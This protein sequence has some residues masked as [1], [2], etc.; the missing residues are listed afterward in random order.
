MKV[1]YIPNFDQFAD[2]YLSTYYSSGVS[3]LKRAAGGPLMLLLGALGA[4]WVADRVEFWLL[5][6]PLLL[7]GTALSLYGLYYTLRPLIN[8]LL[9]WLRRAELFDNEAVK[10][11][12]ELKGAVLHISQGKDRVRLPLEQI[13]SVLHRS[14]N[15]WIITQSD[16][17]VYVPRQGLLSGDHDKFVDALVEKL[18]PEDEED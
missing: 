16:T 11:T 18:T 10:T 17:L 4:I 2:N 5:R 7:A 13:L 9:V 3:T 15:T 12:L 14:S 1:V 8:L 6:Y